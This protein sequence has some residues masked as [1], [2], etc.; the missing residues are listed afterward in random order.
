MPLPKLNESQI[1]QIVEWVAEYIG[2]QR[3]AFSQSASNLDAGQKAAMQPFFPKS[4]LDG[5]KLVVLSNKRVSNPPFYPT[6]VEMGFD[7]ASLPDFSQMA[8]IT[9]VDIVVSHVPFDNSL[10]FHELVHTVQYE[11]L[12]LSRFADKYVRGFLTSGSYAG[13]PLE[14]N[15][16]ELQERFES[17]SVEGEVEDWIFLKLF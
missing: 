16:Y 7:A 9:F 17:L 6:L 2:A 14:R 5:T 8:A 3:K 1:H 11:K 12:G 13:I 4:V 15:A 10:L